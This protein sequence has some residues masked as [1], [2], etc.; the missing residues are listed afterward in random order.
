M[1]HKMMQNFS[2]IIMTILSF[3]QKTVCNSK[4]IF[5]QEQK[6]WTAD[7]KTQIMT[8]GGNGNQAIY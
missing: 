5:C 6:R 8:K 3:L 7:T 2:Q 4:L 1:H